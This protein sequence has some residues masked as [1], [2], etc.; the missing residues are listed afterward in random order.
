MPIYE[1][2]CD[3][4]NERFEKIVINRQQEVSC[5]K[6]SGKKATIQL[7][8]FAT[9]G[10][11]GPPH[12]AGALLRAWRRWARGRL[13]LP[14]APAQAIPMLIGH[15]SLLLFVTGAAII[16]II[17]GPAVMYVVSRSI[18]HGRSA[19]LVF[20]MGIV[21]GTLFYGAGA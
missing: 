6:C 11:G 18:G 2:V 17:P 16:L 19:G 9:A 13:L 10:S 12:P 15:S 20:A 1:Y 4:C 14:L 7:S 21:V 5:P 8:V 3:T